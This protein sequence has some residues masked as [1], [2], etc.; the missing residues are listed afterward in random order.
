MQ[1]YPGSSLCAISDALNVSRGVIYQWQ[2]RG[3]PLDAADKVA[4]K[5]L[6]VH[7]AALWGDLWWEA[8][9]IAS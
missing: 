5:S 6:G 3:I 7:P 9:P 4:V 2:A 8:T 1:N